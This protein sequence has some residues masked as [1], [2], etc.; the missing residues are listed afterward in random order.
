MGDFYNAFP[1]FF[2]RFGQD[3][4]DKESYI[5]VGDGEVRVYH[6]CISNGENVKF[7]IKITK[8]EDPATHKV[9]MFFF[10]F[11]FFFF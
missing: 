5:G 7:Q 2:F 10:F 3:V 1:R 8:I 9:S 4:T 6:G 11:F